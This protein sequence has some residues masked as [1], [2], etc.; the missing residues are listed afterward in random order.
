MDDKN[1]IQFTTNIENQFPEINAATVPKLVE[2]LT[3]E[4]YHGD[5]SYFFIFY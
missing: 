1:Q 4:N 3:Y 5:S 2:L